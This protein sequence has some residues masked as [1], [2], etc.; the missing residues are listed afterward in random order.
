M[1]RFVKAAIGGAITVGLLWWV[2]SDVDYRE[3]AASIGRGNFLLLFVA[4]AV[5][6]SGFLIRALRW[7]VLLVPVYPKTRLRSRFASVSVGFMAN[8]VLPARVGEFARAFTLGRLEP[9]S[10]TAAFGTLVVERFLDGVVLLAF[11][12]LPLR[13]PG[14]PSADALSTGVGAAV[15]A[16]ANALVLTVLVVVVALA[17][18]PNILLRVARRVGEAIAPQR[19]PRLLEILESFLGSLAIMRNP[20]LLAQALVWTVVLWLSQAASVWLGMLAFGI[21]TGFVSAVF[22]QAVV[23]FAVAVP[24]AP[25]FFGTFHAAADFALSGVYG[26]N[27]VDSLAFAFGFHLAAWIP[28]TVIGLVYVWKLGLTLSDVGHADEG[29]DPGASAAGTS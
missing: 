12:T 15:F 11:L 24:S 2:L 18:A 20:A 17:V 19:S 25:G 4:V 10:A 14:F 22:A 16:F 6:T 13:L 3:V 27:Q 8:N 9:V 26:V 28:I 7:H 29:I 21:D 1:N 23:S 5:A